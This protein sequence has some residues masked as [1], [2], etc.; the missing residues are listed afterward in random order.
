MRLLKVFALGGAAL[1]LSAL[2]GC[3]H[4]G[5]TENSRPTNTEDQKARIEQLL[6][7]KYGD[8]FTVLTVEKRKPG[9]AL[10]KTRYQAQATSSAYTGQFNVDVDEDFGAVADD[11]PRLYWNEEIEQKVGRV[12]QVFPQNYDVQWEIVYWVTDETWKST[13]SIDDYLEQGNAYIDFT[14]E[15][16]VDDVT[17]IALALHNALQAERLKYETA[18][19]L[20]KTTVVFGEMPGDTLTDEQIRAKFERDKP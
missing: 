5:S 1:I 19:H 16:N 6:N 7:E 13:D 15:T 17:D 4:R 12:E 14:I 3:F 2:T 20:G 8:H 11:Y 18:W 9:A 10:T